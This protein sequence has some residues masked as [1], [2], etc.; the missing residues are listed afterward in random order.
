MKYMLKSKHWSVLRFMYDHSRKFGTTD[1]VLFF[2]DEKEILSYF[3]F[4]IEEDIA[5]ASSN[6]NAYNGLE[7]LQN[8]MKIASAPS[9]SFRDLLRHGFSY[10][11]ELIDNDSGERNYNMYWHVSTLNCNPKNYKLF[12]IEEKQVRGTKLKVIEP[13]TWF[14]FYKKCVANGLSKDEISFG[15]KSDK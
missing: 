11:R 3:N 9:I 6:M 5:K 4:A 14:R 2:D 7:K 8:V 15:A 1:Q 10:F 12:T 13:L